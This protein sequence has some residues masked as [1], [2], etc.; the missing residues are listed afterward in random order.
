[1]LL[2][3]LPGLIL[4]RANDFLLLFNDIGVLG[5]EVGLLC[6]P[7]LSF[8]LAVGFQLLSQSKEDLRL[9]KLE[10]AQLLLDGVQ[11]LVLGREDHLVFPDDL[12]EV[13]RICRLEGEVRCL[14]FFLLRFLAEA[15]RS[16][17]QFLV[18]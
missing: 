11:V 12:H 1:M 8:F 6:G 3:C 16:R 17:R 7:S 2:G 18:L 13:A 9:I 4:E 15:G 10:C 5:H 14:V